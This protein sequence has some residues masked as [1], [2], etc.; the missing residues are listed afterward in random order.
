[1]ASS[2][3]V[4]EIFGPTIQGEGP[5]IGKVCVFIRFAGCDNDCDWCDTP[6]AKTDTPHIMTVEE[7]VD[8]VNYLSEPTLVVLTGG[9]PLLHNLTSL[10]KELRK[11]GHKIGVETQG[12]IYKPWVAFTDYLV[13]S[14]KPPSSG[15]ITTPEQLTEFLKIPLNI[16]KLQITL[17]IVVGDDLDFSY[18]Q[19]IHTLFPKIPMILQ[20]CTLTKDKIE[21][22]KDDIYR[23]MMWLL[24]KATGSYNMHDVRILPQLH[25]LIWGPK[26][27]V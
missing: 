11:S 23:S 12:T 27:G 15:N 5:Q 4:I 14:P 20:P 1:M 3:P 7:I 25:V 21:Y 10:V 16:D 24:T 26:R 19:T 9:N 18:A 17:K 13:V 6:Y 8:N 2:I 22:T